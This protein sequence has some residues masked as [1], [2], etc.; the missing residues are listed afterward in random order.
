ML[1]NKMQ[2]IQFWI[3]FLS[4]GI[5]MYTT[6]DYGRPMHQTNLNLWPNNQHSTFN[7][8]KI[9]W[10]SCFIGILLLLYKLFC[11]IVWQQAANSSLKQYRAESW[12]YKRPRNAWVV[13]VCHRHSSCAFKASIWTAQHH[14]TMSVFCEFH[15]GLSVNSYS[16]GKVVICAKISK[17]LTIENLCK[18]FNI[19]SGRIWKKKLTLCASCGGGGMIA[20]R[21]WQCSGFHGP[22]DD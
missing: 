15:T 20:A 8:H 12:H 9:S 7:S 3:Y 14:C 4:A 22:P 5:L 21:R 18:Q 2:Y 17:M 19:K 11:P 1:T 6:T 13:T 16:T 10:N